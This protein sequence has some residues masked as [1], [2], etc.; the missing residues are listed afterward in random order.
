MLIIYYTHA[1]RSL[2]MNENGRETEI[3]IEKAK[4]LYE[5]DKVDDWNIAFSRLVQCDFDMEKVDAQ[6]AELDGQS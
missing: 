4:E 2:T 3:G 5:A 1:T 6:Y